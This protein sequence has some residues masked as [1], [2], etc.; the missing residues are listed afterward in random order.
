M[1]RRFLISSVIIVCV[2]FLLTACSL[3]PKPTALSDSRFNGHFYYHYVKDGLES[4]DDYYKYD[5]DGSNKV[6]H[7]Y[8]YKWYSKTSGWHYSGD[9][10]GDDVGYYLEFEVND[11]HTMYRTKLWNNEYSSWSEWLM[12]EFLDE[13]TLRLYYTESLYRDYTKI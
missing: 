6:W 3:N 8:K 11:D 9:Y 4:H 7:Y 2:V 13:S 1:N 10:I 5:F 12:Y